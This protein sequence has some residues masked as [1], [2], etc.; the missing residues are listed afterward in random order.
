MSILKL[1]CFCLFQTSEEI[2]HHLQ[3][4]VDFG[5]NVMKEFLGESYVHCGVSAVYSNFS[6]F[7]YVLTILTS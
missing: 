3:N 6:T 5:K 1:P 7:G 2:L 4:I